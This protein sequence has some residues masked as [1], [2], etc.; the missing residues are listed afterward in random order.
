MHSIHFCKTLD[1]I[2]IAY[3]CGGAG[4]PLIKTPT[5]LNH[6]EL[7]V[8][9]AVWRPWIEQFTQRFQLIR[10]DARGCGLSDRNVGQLS[11]AT[12]RLDLEAVV[13]ASGLRRFALFGGSQGGA[14]AIDYAARNPDQV[15]HL[16]LYGTYLRGAL[17]R[18]QSPQAIEQANVLLK[19]VQ[20]GWGQENS[21]FRQV[22]ATQFMPDGTLEQLRAFDD[23]QRQTASPETAARLLQSFYEIDVSEQ[24]AQVVCPTLVMHSRDDARIPFEE[25]RQVASAIKNAEFVS[26]GK[27]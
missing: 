21:A 2:T 10:Y 14:V 4:Y 6:V 16:I 26:L 7:D 19:L 22:F 23:I 9:S 3:A 15:S 17:K 25:G 20:L 11:F 12:H 1:G 18:N 24:A 27:H 5:W 13:A 8:K